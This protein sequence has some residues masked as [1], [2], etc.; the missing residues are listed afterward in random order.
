MGPQGPVA[1][2]IDLR[3]FR[4]ALSGRHGRLKPTLMDQSV[5]A[6]SGQSTHGRNLLAGPGSSPTRLVADMDADEVKRLHVAMARVLRTSVRHG[7]VPGLPR[8]SPGF[9]TIRTRV[10]RAV[11]HPSHMVGRAAGCRCAARTA[12]PTSR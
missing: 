4:D 3:A 7:R 6:G 12:S 11:A 8:G 10:A 9:A 1:L 2:G 5:V